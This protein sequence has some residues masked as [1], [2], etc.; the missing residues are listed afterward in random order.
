MAPDNGQVDIDN[1]KTEVND[2]V[3]FSCYPGYILTGIAQSK[4]NTSGSWDASPPS[5]IVESKFIKLG[6]YH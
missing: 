5:C 2:T 1:G 3:T 4:C 6:E